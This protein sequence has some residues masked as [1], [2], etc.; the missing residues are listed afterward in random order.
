MA[1]FVTAKSEFEIKRLQFMYFQAE[2]LQSAQALAVVTA[3][4]EQVRS[5]VTFWLEITTYLLISVC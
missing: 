4:P 5:L 3:V 2:V 1:A